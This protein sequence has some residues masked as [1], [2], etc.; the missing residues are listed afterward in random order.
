MEDGLAETLEAAIRCIVFCQNREIK[1]SSNLT[2]VSRN[3]YLIYVLQNVNCLILIPNKLEMPVELLL[4]LY[5][6]SST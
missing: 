4:F 1:Q 2:L 3:D 6:L 5:A